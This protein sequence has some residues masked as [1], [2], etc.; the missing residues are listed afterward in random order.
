MTGRGTN[1]RRARNGATSSYTAA[2]AGGN[3]ADDIR[4][5]SRNTFDDSIDVESLREEA[6]RLL[7]D[8]AAAV[9]EQQQ[10]QQQKHGEHPRD[11]RRSPTGHR[12]TG[13]ST[14]QAAPRRKGRQ[15]QEALEGK[16]TRK[17]QVNLPG[18]DCLHCVC[19]CVCVSKFIDVV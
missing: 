17:S 15:A 19:L 1:N 12:A 6:Q 5:G 2:A 11:N 10:N 13:Q 16:A 3:S 4:S 8:E 14:M 7:I 9:K 18:Y